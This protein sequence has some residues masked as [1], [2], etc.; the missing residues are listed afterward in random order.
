VQ[1]PPGT[2]KTTFIAEAVVQL[3]KRFPEWRIL[4]TSQTH[5]ALDNALERIRRLA[6]QLRM[7]RVAGRHTSSRVAD[8][9]RDLLLD[10]RV[11]T[12][13]EEVLA[14]GH[15]FLEQF[16]AGAGISKADVKTGLLIREIGS[17]R[18]EIDVLDEE[19]GVRLEQLKTPSTEAGD[20]D[21]TAE[22]EE[23][24]LL[25]EEI[26]RI[27]RRIKEVGRGLEPLEEALRSREELADEL[28]AS[29]VDELAREID[30]YIPAHAA[31]IRALIE[32]HNDW[33]TRLG[34]GS[35]FHAAM[36]QSSQVT[37]A[38]C[39]GAL[40][41]RGTDAIGYDLCIVDEAS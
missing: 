37:A 17:R 34:R 12:W 1:G 35:E 27:R 20:G 19:L 2:G 29:S 14:K 23:H 30:A 33:K 13:R 16:A 38:T 31:G 39:L 21:G 5:V 18:R 36:I 3:T 4:I 9:V 10:N 41:V 6:P 15:Q 7:I 32:V 22:S 25:Q 11:E 26:A 8:S 28:L 40:S 24:E